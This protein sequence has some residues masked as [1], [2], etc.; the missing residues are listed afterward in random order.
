M[1]NRIIIVGNDKLLHRENIE[2]NTC[3]V[4]GTIVHLAVDKNYAGYIYIANEIKEDAA[5]AISQLKKLGV[6]KTVMLTGD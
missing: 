3:N 5:L 2:H 6:E 1:S 4:E